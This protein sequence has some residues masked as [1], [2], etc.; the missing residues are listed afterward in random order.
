MAGWV[1]VRVFKVMTLML[2]WGGGKEAS[3]VGGNGIWFH[4]FAKPQARCI[5]TVK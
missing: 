4:A 5:K 1:V 3:V 2:L